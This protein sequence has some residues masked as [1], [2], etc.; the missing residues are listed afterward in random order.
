[1][2]G[3]LAW[4]GWSGPNSRLLGFGHRRCCQTSRALPATS[5][6]FFFLR[7]LPK[8]NQPQCRL[9][10][11]TAAMVRRVMLFPGLSMCPR[12]KLLQ[13]VLR[14]PPSPA[15]SG[16]VMADDARESFA[17]T[18]L[19]GWVDWGRGVA[20]ASHYLHAGRA[21]WHSAAFLVMDRH[22][23]RFP[24][25]HR[26]GLGRT[27]GGTWTKFGKDPSMSFG[28]EA[29]LDTTSPGSSCPNLR[30]CLVCWTGKAVSH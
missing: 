20:D 14:R 13:E 27:N 22:R 8:F 1:M 23:F 21:C 19:Q 7:L 24:K 10:A 15:A 3:S 25:D 28:F 29:G 16:K 11:C 26:T 4:P 12:L 17:N 6:V 9:G 30:N 18:H 2:Q 5:F